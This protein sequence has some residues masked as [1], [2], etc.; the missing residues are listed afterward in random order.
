MNQHEKWAAMPAV[1]EA[2]RKIEGGAELD[3]EW[4]LAYFER[5]Y[6]ACD[7]IAKRA[8]KLNIT[9]AELRSMVR[10]WLTTSVARDELQQAFRAGLPEMVE[11][12]IARLDAEIL[13]E[14]AMKITMPKVIGQMREEMA[15]KSSIS[16]EV[17]Q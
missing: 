6:E 9:N 14:G 8:A 12:W 15:K 17:N 1:R 3:D 5:D 16:W 11:A 10:A 13:L 7:E 2:F 4:D